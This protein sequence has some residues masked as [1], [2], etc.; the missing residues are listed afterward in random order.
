MRFWDTYALLQ[1][2]VD[3]PDR[4]PLIALL[5]EYSDVLAWLG[6]PAEIVSAL[7]RREHEEA[8]TTEQVAEALTAVRALSDIWH[9]IVPSMP[10]RRTAERLPRTRLLRAAKASLVRSV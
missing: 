5:D 1:L 6:T 9:E 2:F 4:E 3:E 7:A 8:L 10:V